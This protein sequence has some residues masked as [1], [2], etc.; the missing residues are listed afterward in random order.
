M[1]QP[2]H[3]NAQA[4]TDNDSDDLIDAVLDYVIGDGDDD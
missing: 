1:F 4:S 2:Q 3:Q